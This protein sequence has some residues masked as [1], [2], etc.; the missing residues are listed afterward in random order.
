MGVVNCWD[1]MKCG[2]EPGGEH[3]AE[4]GVCP[5]AT[6][7]KLHGMNGGTNGG[8]ICWFVAGTMCGG[9]LQGSVAKKFERC[10]ECEFYKL[11]QDE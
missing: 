3:V 5:A 4:M 10:Y 8:R 9:E 7:V 6:A 11:V 2:R 1:H